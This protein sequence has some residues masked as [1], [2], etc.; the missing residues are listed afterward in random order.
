MI[1][2]EWKDIK[3]YEGIYQISNIGNVKALNFG[4]PTHKQRRGERLLKKI[5]S[6]TGYFV[7]TLYKERIGIQHF[8][9]RLVADNFIPNPFNYPVVDHINTNTKDNRVENLRWV[10]VKGNVNN[11][12][13]AKRRY[14]AV[15][16]SLKGK[17]GIESLK[18][19]AVAQFSKDGKYIKTWGCMSDAWRYYG[20][21][22]GCITKVCQGKQK[23]AGGF[24]W[25]Y[26]E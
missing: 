14:E 12:I 23:T 19:K 13:S 9:H 3:G 16:N 26:A 17:F 21:D 4:S 20:L 1:T 5:T 18:H 15:C 6:S 24:I 25:R 10:T 11:P 7:V 2:E 8:I 22:S